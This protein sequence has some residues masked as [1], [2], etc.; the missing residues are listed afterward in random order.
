MEYPIKNGDPE[1]FKKKD[2]QISEFK[3]KTEKHDLENNLKSLKNDNEYYRKK[4]KSFNK[5]KIVLTITEIFLDLLQ[6]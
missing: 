2:D 6:H 1:L 4:Y 5:M 3:F